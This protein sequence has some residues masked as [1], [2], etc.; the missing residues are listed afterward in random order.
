LLGD[1]LHSQPLAINYGARGG[2]YDANN[3]DI[4]LL[5]GTNDGF[6]RM[7]RNTTPSATEDGGESWSIIP[8]EVVPVLDRLHANS[9]G[10]PVHPNG[11][12]GS[13]SAYTV[14]VNFD[15]SII[16]TDGDTAH[17]YFGLRRGGKSY[18]ALDISD[19]DA[20]KVLWTLSKGTP[21]T[22]FAELGQTWSKPQVGL[23]KVGS[24]V[25]PVVVFAGG[26][27]GDDDGDDLG[28]LGKDAA[29]RQ[30]RASIAPSPGVDDDEGNAIYIVN[31][32]DGSLVWK[33]TKGGSIGYNS[34]NKEFTHPGLVDSFPSSV[35]AI[36][37]NADQFL[38]RIYVA[39][40]GGVV[41][42]IDLA[43]MFDHDTNLAT[44]KILVHN[45]PSVW[46][47]GKL[48][49]VGRHVSG[50]TTIVDDRRFFN[51]PDVVQSRDGIGPFDGVL[52]GSGDREGAEA[53]V[54]H[55]ER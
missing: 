22:A 32:T 11:T 12:D 6:M 39:D 14:D 1:P 19:P 55:G 2:G 53:D 27:N 33:A 46:T 48:L 8:R 9:P 13:P 28:D 34:T 25:I 35:S 18:Y 30:T 51:R 42:R 40:T 31:A 38:D 17:I 21:G 50:F 43:G 3:P 24:T 49:S 10:T 23:V 15:G 37:T 20:P 16:S 44:P 29:N 5:M 54:P 45:E 26:Y 4:R 36:D 7:F 47:A 52:I 41:W